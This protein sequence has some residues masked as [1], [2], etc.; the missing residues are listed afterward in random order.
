M[1]RTVKFD[2]GDLVR[3]GGIWRNMVG[4]AIADSRSWW[5]L[6]GH[7]EVNRCMIDRKDVTKIIK[8]QCVPKRYLKW[9]RK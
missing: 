5:V 1:R 9:F 2:L 6:H 8:K 3:V 4:V 7:V